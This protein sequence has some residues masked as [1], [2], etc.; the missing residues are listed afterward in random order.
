M[1]RRRF[2]PSFMLMDEVENR[3]GRAQPRV[4]YKLPPLEKGSFFSAFRRN[5]VVQQ[6]TESS[7]RKNRDVINFL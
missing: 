5:K 7:E 1:K 2:A 4:K 6:S 3:H